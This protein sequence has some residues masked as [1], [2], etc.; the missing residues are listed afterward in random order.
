MG[1]SIGD[2]VAGL[3]SV[4]GVLS[5]LIRR[6]NTKLGSKLDI[7]MLDCQVAILENA[8]SRFSIEKKRE[9]LRANYIQ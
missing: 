6:K 2:I 3:F 9:K 5:Q 1:T 4:I 7:S 8:V